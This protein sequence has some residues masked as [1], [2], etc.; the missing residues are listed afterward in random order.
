MAQKRCGQG[1]VNI[2]LIMALTHLSTGG[3]PG[4]VQECGGRAQCYA[5]LLTVYSTG[6]GQPSTVQVI[7]GLTVEKVQLLATGPIF[8]SGWQLWTQLFG[9]SNEYLYDFISI[10]EGPFVSIRHSCPVIEVQAPFPGPLSRGTQLGALASFTLTL[11]LTRE[12]SC[13]QGL[14]ASLMNEKADIYVVDFVFS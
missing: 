3:G 5:L 10:Y 6:G 2:L 12:I 4:A 9:Q 14:N 13:S 11:G 1:K 7:E 8:E